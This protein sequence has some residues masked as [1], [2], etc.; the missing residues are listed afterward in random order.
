MTTWRFCIGFM[1]SAVVFV[2]ASVAQNY[3]T[4]PINIITPFPP[5]GAGDIMCRLI[6]QKLTESWGQQVITLNRGGGNTVIGTEFAARA[7]AD[8]YNL[9]LGQSSNMTIVPALYK[10]GSPKALNYDTM[11]DFVPVAFLGVGPLMFVVHPSVPAKTVKEFI[12]VAK[13]RPGKLNYNSSASGG[14]THL[15]MELFK[16]M[17]GVDIVHIPYTGGGPQVIALVSGHVDVAFASITNTLPQV[18][19]QRLRALA[20]SSSARSPAVPD[21][22]TVAESGLPGFQVDP[23][24]GVLTQTA[25]PKD[26]VIK[27]NAEINKYLLDSNVKERMTVLGVDVIRKT[28]EEFAKFL[29][30]EMAMWTKV[31]KASGAKVD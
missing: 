5:G 31:V 19:A 14:T 3:P 20:I 7:S 25:T 18:K 30:E 6:G 16:N 8:G 23:W 4:K 1:L 10:Y 27:L 26:I 22:P 29:H 12:A 28:P 11:K 15:S 24:F 2:A 17:A 21:L 13:S 9:F